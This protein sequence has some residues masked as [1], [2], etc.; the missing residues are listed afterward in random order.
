ME[1]LL[2][3]KEQSNFLEKFCKNY[4]LY[5]SCGSDFHG[6]EVKPN[7]HMGLATEGKKMDISVISDWINKVNHILRPNSSRQKFA[8][9]IKSNS[10]FN[11]NNIEKIIE[12]ESEQGIEL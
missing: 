9:S 7:N 1:K 8:E 12:C 10:E 11:V 6:Y 2:K 5:K 3:Y 4:N